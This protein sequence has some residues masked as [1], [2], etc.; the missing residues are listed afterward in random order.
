[1]H[2]HTTQER[3]SHPRLYP[4]PHTHTS[5]PDGAHTLPDDLLKSQVAAARAA[6]AAAAEA[7]SGGRGG[8]G[9]DSMG[10]LEKFPTEYSR[11]DSFLAMQVLR[12]H[13]IVTDSN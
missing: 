2:A 8:G 13:P 12:A 6:E 5:D 9:I 4:A 11:H 3:L 1:M 10:Q 7:Q